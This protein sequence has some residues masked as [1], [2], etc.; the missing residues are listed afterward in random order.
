M[1]CITLRNKTANEHL[2]H[3]ILDGVVFITKYHIRL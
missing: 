3:Y 2:I 1:D